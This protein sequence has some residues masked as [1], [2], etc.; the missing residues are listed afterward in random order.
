MNVSRPHPSAFVAA[1]DAPLIDERAATRGRSATEGGDERAGAKARYPF[2]LQPREPD[3]TA[4]TVTRVAAT[5][6][7]EA[8]T[9][10][11][12]TH[13]PLRKPQTG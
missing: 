3:R 12:S 7:A 6:P 13:H 5:R 2:A 10:K 9:P 1:N 8:R 4:G 11:P